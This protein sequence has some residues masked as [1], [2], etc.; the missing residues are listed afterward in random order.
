MTVPG[1]TGLN[2]FQST[3]ILQ[4]QSSWYRPVGYENFP[5]LRKAAATKGMSGGDAPTCCMFPAW[6]ISRCLVV[7]LSFSLC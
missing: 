3:V 7:K 2:V 4:D 1:L 6:E 5:L